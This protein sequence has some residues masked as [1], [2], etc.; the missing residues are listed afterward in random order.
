MAAAFCAAAAAH[1]DS[2]WTPNYDLAD[3]AVGQVGPTSVAWAVPASFTNGTT[4]LSG[5]DYVFPSAGGYENEFITETGALYDQD[6]LAPG[7]TNLFYFSGTNSDLHGADV[8]K[9]P[10]GSIDM[11][12]MQGLFKPSDFT[13]ASAVPSATEV[14]EQAR[15]VDA[16]QIGPDKIPADA[17][18]LD[19]WNP[20]Y[21]GADD[22]SLLQVPGSSSLAWAIPDTTWT[23]AG[24]T[25]LTGTDYVS[26]TVILNHVYG[27][28]NE[29]VTN[30]GAVYDEH[31]F[32]PNLANLYY[33]GGAA[34][35]HPVDILQTSFGNFDISWAAGLLTPT[36]YAAATVLTP[37]TA[38]QDSGLYSAL[39]L[40]PGL[41][42]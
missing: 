8:L 32:S 21:A 23:P 19:G 16:L 40:L 36:D 39:D 31:V 22:A 12:L 3:A 6:Q 20:T 28:D 1:A 15:L 26:N 4:T 38:L 24:G 5:T 13:Q 14:A 27:S 2:G 25:A 17:P 35:D 34:G 33:D 7:Y 42:S 11:P 9:T 37:L 30:T 18:P 29:F 10:F 41:T